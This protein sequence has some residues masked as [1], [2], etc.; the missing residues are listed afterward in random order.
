MSDLCKA[1]LKHVVELTLRQSIANNIT[2]IEMESL[3]DEL[4]EARIK[5]IDLSSVSL[6]Y[7]GDE[8]ITCEII[9]KRVCILKH[10]SIEEA[11]SYCLENFCD[12]SIVSQNSII[13]VSQYKNSLYWAVGGSQSLTKLAY[14]I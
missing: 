3:I 9:G 14:W 13:N 2:D 11:I 12:I 5:E 6:D 1:S 10:K 4:L 8:I 7:R